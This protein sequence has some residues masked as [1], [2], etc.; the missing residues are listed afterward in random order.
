MVF[1][2]CYASSF[3]TMPARAD[4]LTGKYAFTS[5]GWAPL[6]PEETTLAQLLTEAGYVTFGVTDTP[7]FVRRGYGYDAGFADFQWFRG[8]RGGY[9]REDVTRSWRREEDRFAAVTMSTAEIWLEQHYK[10][11]FFL[12]VDTW[13]PHEPW[14]PP[15]HYVEQY[16]EGYDG[17]ECPVACYWDWEEAGL[18]EEDLKLAR[19]FYCGEVTMV[20]RWVGRLL[21]RIES[22]DLMEE[23]AIVFTSDHG[24]YLGEHGLFG[25]A[26]MRSDKGFYAGPGRPA[27]DGWLKNLFR[28]PETGEVAYGDHEWCRCPIY[29][30]VGGVPLMIHVPQVGPAR[31][32]SLVTLPDLMPTVLELAGVGIPEAVQAKSLVP[33]LAGEHKAVHDVVV[34]SWP[35]YNPGQYSRVVDDLQRRLRELSPS[36]VTAEGWTLIYSIAGEPVELYRTESDPEQERNVFVGNEDVAE[37]LHRR[38]V[39]FLEGAGTD[40]GLLATRRSLV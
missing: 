40:E 16:Y 22:L 39:A 5:L 3:P 1:E 37:K 35:L 13:D 38:F 15:S 11:K 20:D 14:D 18:T 19:A 24:F 21:E 2:R 8:Q 31:S 34:T 10:D 36:T 33:L 32:D 17:Q 9:E 4:L 7:F 6:P 23:T 29:E 12:Y 30:E 28:S 27:A 25:K 26:K